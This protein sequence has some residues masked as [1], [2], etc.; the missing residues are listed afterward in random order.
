MDANVDTSNG[1]EAR[2]IG[3]PYDVNTAAS[4]TFI[5]SFG[6]GTIIHLIQMCWLKTWFF[7]PFLIGCIMETFGYYGRYW[8]SQEPENFKAYVLYDLLVLPAPIF[9]AAT[10]YMSISRIILALDAAELS[11]VRPK[12]F[13]KMFVM[14][15]VICF[16]VQIAGTGMTVTISEKMQKIGQIVVVVGLVFQILVFVCFIWLVVVFYRRCGRQ[17]GAKDVGLKWRRYVLALLAASGCIVLRNLVIGIQHAQGADGFVASHEV[18]AYLFEAVPIFA[19]VCIFAVYQPGR[20]QKSV[21][22]LKM[23]SSESDSIP[24]VQSEEPTLPIMDLHESGR[25]Y[26]AYRP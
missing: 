17:D 13:S 10:M 18:F 16:L 25:R 5:A 19:V 11:P 6:L 2:W 21:R 3:L 22:G 8:L 9:L 15:D 26:E 23:G 12:W 4:L 14:G 24:M 1:G 20:L 7:I